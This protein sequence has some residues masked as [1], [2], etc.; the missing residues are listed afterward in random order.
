VRTPFLLQLGVLLFCNRLFPLNNVKKSP[1][2]IS[3][4]SHCQS[5]FTQLLGRTIISDSLQLTISSL[6][7]CSASVPTA[8]ALFVAPR[9]ADRQMRRQR[10][11]KDRVFS[12]RVRKVSCKKAPVARRFESSESS[13]N[14]RCTRCLEASQVV[15]PLAYRLVREAQ[16][17]NFPPEVFH[18]RDV[19][20]DSPLFK[21]QARA[22]LCSVWDRSS[23]LLTRN[24]SRVAWS[25]GSTDPYL[26][27]IA[28]L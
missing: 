10:V 15:P 6:S 26:R 8:P 19:S 4:A 3:S 1:F 21:T 13:Q 7:F 23:L 12:L 25:S 28:W 14:H 5:V 24:V 11:P 22:E 9:H 16:V 27:R 18:I 17:S 20:K 2:F